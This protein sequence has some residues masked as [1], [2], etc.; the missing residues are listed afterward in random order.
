MN[1]VTLPVCDFLVQFPSLI[2]AFCLFQAD[3][4]EHLRRAKEQ[5]RRHRAGVAR[6]ANFAQDPARDVV[7]FVKW[8]AE[9]GVGAE[10][11]KLPN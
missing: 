8:S 9:T 11:M 4:T 3:L 7:E 2:L 5:L 10:L 1:I 6:L